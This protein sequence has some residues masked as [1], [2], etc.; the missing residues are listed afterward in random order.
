MKTFQYLAICLL[1]VFLP[2]VVS[3]QDDVYDYTQPKTTTNTDGSGNTYVTN[4]YY[5]SD[6]NDEQYV[7]ANDDEYEYYYSSRLRRFHNP[8]Q[9]SSYYSGYYVDRYWY[10]PDPFLWGQTIYYDPF[11]TSYYYSPVI[12]MR[13]RPW[14]AWGW[15]CNQPHVVYNNNYYNPYGNNYNPYGGYAWNNNYYNPYNPWNGYGYGYGYGYGNNITVI[16]NY[17][18]YYTGD[19]GD[20][21]GG[22]SY[23]PRQGKD[24]YGNTNTSNN[25]GNYGIY[26]VGNGTG[27][28]PDRPSTSPPQG[29]KSD[30]VGISVPHG[31]VTTRPDRNNDTDVKTPKNTNPNSG[32]TPNTNQPT[33]VRP[34]RPVKVNPNNTFT[35]TTKPENEIVRPSKNTEPAKNNDVKDNKID[36]PSKQNNFDPKNNDQPKLQQQQEEQA[37]PKSETPKMNSNSELNRTPKHQKAP[38]V[39]KSDRNENRPKSSNFNSGGSQGSRNSEPKATQPAKVRESNSNNNNNNSKKESK[40]DRKP[41]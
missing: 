24:T 6:K 14:W 37:K 3:A 26:P 28:R 38:K 27:I 18:P 2:L 29:G 39:D 33:D 21:Y 40:S 1:A 5:D 11:A 23:G 36:L 4:N 16:N 35:P 25:N 34:D 17:G 32:F 8:V 30:G 22:K 7:F 12:F 13:P 15:G 31:N 41:R 10:D 9:G 20:Y 19:N